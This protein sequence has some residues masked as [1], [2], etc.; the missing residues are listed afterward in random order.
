MMPQ[1]IPTDAEFWRGYYGG[2]KPEIRGNAFYP[3]KDWAA[4]P[5]ITVS[6]NKGR[7]DIR[8]IRVLDG[9]REELEAK[10]AAELA[11]WRSALEDAHDRMDGMVGV[12]L[13]EESRRNE[14]KL[15]AELNQILLDNE[16][17]AATALCTKINAERDEAI[18]NRM[19]LAR[20][21]ALAPYWFVAGSIIGSV[22]VALLNHLSTITG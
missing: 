18:N 2:R 21:R 16:R 6:P 5:R 9:T 3:V 17:A 7:I 4:A 8:N 13:L 14:A 12:D 10:H 20:V 22:G 1:P 15:R 19:T 11:K